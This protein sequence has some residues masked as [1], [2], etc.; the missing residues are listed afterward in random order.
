MNLFSEDIKKEEIRDDV[1]VN[2]VKLVAVPLD[3][4]LDELRKERDRLSR[5][6][7]ELGKLA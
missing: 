1:F 2:L 5:R 4:Y 6:I 3:Y 7:K